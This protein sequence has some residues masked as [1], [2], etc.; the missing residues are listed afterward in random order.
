MYISRNKQFLET[1]EFG[2]TVINADK[3]NS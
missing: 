1:E 2:F 3:F